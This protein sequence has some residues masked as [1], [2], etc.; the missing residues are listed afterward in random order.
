MGEH[1]TTT[2]EPT[3]ARTAGDVMSR[4][5]VTI[6]RRMPMRDAA[7]ILRRARI[8][9]A[10]VVDEQGRCVGVLSAS[11]FLHWADDECPAPAGVAGA[12]CSYQVKGRLLTGEDAVICTLAEGSCP[13]QEMRPL[14]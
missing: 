7:G 2:V 9:G 13:L 6:P 1:M 10:P 5:V 14:S 3:L 8:S 12:A 11:D 4:E